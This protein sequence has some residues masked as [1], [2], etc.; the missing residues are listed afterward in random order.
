[1]SQNAVVEIMAA[2]KPW[3]AIIAHNAG[4]SI[5]R[6]RRTLLSMLDP[7]KIM[8]INVAQAAQRGDLVASRS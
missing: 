1:M 8:A 5:K 4:E 6:G 2:S 3:R 7:T